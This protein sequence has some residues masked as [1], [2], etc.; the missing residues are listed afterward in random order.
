MSTF[1]SFRQ[2]ALPSE[3]VGFDRQQWEREH[4]RQLSESEKALT[5]QAKTYNDYHAGTKGL[6]GSERIAA[7]TAYRKRLGSMVRVIDTEPR[8]WASAILSRIADGEIVSPIVEKY[9]KEAL[10]ITE[11][12]I[13]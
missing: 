4:Q 6:K 3:P 12:E 2:G 10:N 7:L 9:A 1:K 8:A 11:K 5:E 13:A